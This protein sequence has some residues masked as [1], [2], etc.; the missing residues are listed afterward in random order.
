MSGNNNNK[1]CRKGR[2]FFGKF[3]V[4]FLVLF[5]LL[6]KCSG[7]L[8]DVDPIAVT[9][10]GQLLGTFGESREGKDYLQFLGVP[11]ARVPLTFQVS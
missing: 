11:Y 9:G 4:H 5:V 6:E 7:R 3:L 1:L 10:Q 8:E 2:L